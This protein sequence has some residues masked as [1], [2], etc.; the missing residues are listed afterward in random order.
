[1][2]KN[3]ISFLG[4]LICFFLFFSSVAEAKF[5]KTFLCRIQ[6]SYNSGDEKTLAKY[7]VLLGTKAQYNDIDGNTW[8]TIHA[9]NGKPGYASYTEIYPYEFAHI[10]K[11]D[12]DT[13]QSVYTNSIARYDKNIGYG[14]RGNPLGDISHD[15]P[16][17]L[18]RTNSGALVTLRKYPTAYI[19]D[20]G[21]RAFQTYSIQA[22]HDDFIGQ[23]WQTD[24]MFSDNTVP[25]K[26]SLISDWPARYQTQAA[27][28]AAMND[29][30]N[31]L[32]VGLH[33][34]GL[35]FACNRGYTNDVDGA[36][37]WLD[38]DA[39]A[40]PPDA[41]LEEGAFVTLWG[42]EAYFDNETRWKRS[43]DVLA[44]TTHSKA[45][46]MSHVKSGSTNGSAID[47]YGNKVTFWDALWYAMGSFILGKNDH[48]YFMMRYESNYDAFD[49]Y[50]PEYDDI[51]LGTAIGGYHVSS[52]SG[53]NIYWR[54]FSNGYV[55]VNPTN[56][57]VA[58]ISLPEI[59]KMRTHEN[60][61]VLLENLP[62]INNININSHR[63]AILYKS[64][65][66]KSSTSGSQSPQPEIAPP[67]GLKIT[68]PN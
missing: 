48:S 2:K 22:L 3:K 4:I 19:L 13:M 46:F 21:N 50:F 5:I 59:C 15:N 29:F 38:L 7:D 32:T 65:L 49:L 52:Y 17:F 10:S 61:S 62:N 6:G 14:D 54:Q 33:K 11:S 58:S 36:Q 66:S 56:Y 44:A 45:L 40:N 64:N 8:G 31:A 23:S 24:G 43:L 20:F 42:A 39:S 53:H 30:L 26:T 68:I 12:Q 47:Q 63:A 34:M 55:Y 35:K 28:S 41:V 18:L 1:M 9:L 25:I 27:W 67:T 16:T 60:L 51:D 37:G 57:N